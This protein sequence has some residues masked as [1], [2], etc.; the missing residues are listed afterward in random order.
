MLRK[1][2]CLV[3]V[4]ALVLVPPALAYI[5]ARATNDSS[6]FTQSDDLLHLAY[7]NGPFSVFT[8]DVSRQLLAEGFGDDG[9]YTN[10]TTI[11]PWTRYSKGVLLHFD[12]TLRSQP[13]AAV[14]WLAMINCDTNGTSFSDVDDI[15]TICR[16]L[17]AQA[18]VL[19]SLTAQGC[20]I[21]AEYISDFEKVLDVY[22]T[23]SLQNARIIES[24]FGNVNSSA[25][26]YDSEALNASA[27]LIDALLANN[28]LSVVGNVPI[29]VTSTEDMDDAAATETLA[30]S[31]T[32]DDGASPTSFSPSDVP[33]VTS[34]DGSNAAI[35]TSPA[36]LLRQMKRQ[37][38]TPA[39][40]SS[41]TSTRAAAT[42]TKASPIPT[43]A[44]NY[45]G[46]VVA[47]RNLTVGGLNS[48]SAPSPS[49]T[50]KSHDGPSTGLAMIILYSITGVV[51]FLFFAVILC[52]AVRAIR[53]PERYG[54]RVGFGYSNRG[55]GS[56]QEGGAQNRAQ[57]LARAVLD[58][59]PVVRFGGGSG[60]H[61]GDER[62]GKD[63]ESGKPERDGDA[64]HKDLSK[65][66]MDDV[67]LV[68]L[69]PTLSAIPRAVG[70]E[71]EMRS[72]LLKRE[73]EEEEI[74]E[75]P[76]GATRRPE[77]RESI[78]ISSFHS[79]VS[80][81]PFIDRPDPTLGT[82]SVIGASSPGDS[83]ALT[84]AVLPSRT[85]N[86]AAP[87]TTETTHAKDD[88][89]DRLSCPICVCEFAEGDSIRILPCDA[90]HQ[91]HVECI[92]PWLLGVSRLCPLCRLDL[93]ENL[94]SVTGT[95]GGGGGS[96]VSGGNERD[97]DN[98][99]GG[100]S[101]G[102]GDGDARE[103]E[104]E[105]REEERVV[106]HLRGLLNR[107]SSSTTPT[108][109]TAD[110]S[111][112]TTTTGGARSRARSHSLTFGYLVAD[113]LGHGEGGGGAAAA[114]AAGRDTVGLRSRFAKYVAV[115]RRRRDNG[116][117]GTTSSTPPRTE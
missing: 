89:E 102:E 36:R 116:S 23:T 64:S 68:R 76:D 94:A 115:R 108:T 92:D 21:N 34:S 31:S 107:G 88:D 93:G 79:A 58:T 72:E 28:A 111:S 98:S 117:L 7:Y 15:F 43:V 96:S 106:R 82:L 38:A 71:G 47:A 69:A 13:P 19:Y 11:V 95:G 44:I 45:L 56:G 113:Q 9:N 30:P 29:N 50:S 87:G 78:S 81:S 74:I 48:S 65:E 49:T 18:A 17:G 37:A 55:A 53:Y 99:R 85:A 32:L 77:L 41:G 22:A 62:Q 83:A 103:R 3:L 67:E 70:S 26:K 80:A 2:V 35:S 73:E 75:Q 16:D 10:T 59:F 110:P 84:P 40:A 100:T 46:A 91:F 97:R 6:A 60:G 33:V 8:A 66:N 12:E 4:L 57:G 51:T 25:W 42:R 109:P 1:P 105:R 27:T 52:G 63:E 86:L 39:P 61:G 114:A 5:P 104:R 101:D 20:A 54:P 112:T 90:R 14:P 24:Q